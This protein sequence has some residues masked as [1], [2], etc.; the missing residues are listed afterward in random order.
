M[1]ILCYLSF[2]EARSADVSF[3]FFFSSL[4]GGKSGG[5]WAWETF[6]SWHTPQNQGMPSSCILLVC[7]VRGVPFF[8]YF[9]Q[10]IQFEMKAIWGLIFHQFIICIWSL[11]SKCFQ[12]PRCKSNL[13]QCEE[14]QYDWCRLC[15][16]RHRA[17]IE[18]QSCSRWYF[19]SS[20]GGI[21]GW[22]RTHKWFIVSSLFIK[23]RLI[24][25]INLYIIQ[26]P[27]HAQPL[28][29]RP[30]WAFHKMGTSK[31]HIYI[32]FSHK[33]PLAKTIR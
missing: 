5:I 32:F 27:L 10:S 22:T 24:I 12:H 13:P 25:Y 26:A 23:Y 9:F 18:V 14:T 2:K 4:L 19:G 15:V 30:K 16:D 6:I 21:F 7:K 1:I 3:L 28:K 8:I 17:G 29:K 11:M 33:L 31:E 20:V